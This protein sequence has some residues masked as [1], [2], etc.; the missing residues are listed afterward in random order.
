MNNLNWSPCGWRILVDPEYSKMTDWGLEIIQPDRTGI[1]ATTKGKVVAMGDACF[2]GDRFHG[3]WCKVGD[4]VLYARYGGVI[5]EDPD[6]KKKYV[7]L[8]D[9]DILGVY[10]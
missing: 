7:V 3:S 6:T 8:N 1:A 10:Q 9:E 5:I 4:V 2:H